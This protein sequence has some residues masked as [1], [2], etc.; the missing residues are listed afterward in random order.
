TFVAALND[1]DDSVAQTHIKLFHRILDM[2]IRNKSKARDDYICN[3]V[4]T[5]D[6]YWMLFKPGTILLKGLGT[7]KH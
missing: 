1:E 2:E 5:Y 6:T 4:I 3:E 7:R